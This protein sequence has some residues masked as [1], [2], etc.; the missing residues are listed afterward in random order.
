ML[1]KGRDAHRISLPSICETCSATQDVRVGK[2]SCRPQK[3]L[4]HVRAMAKSS[5]A[6]QSTTHLHAAYT[7]SLS[8]VSLSWQ[9]NSDISVRPFRPRV[10]AP[11]KPVPAASQHHVQAY[12]ML[13]DV[14][15]D[16]RQQSVVFTAVFSLLVLFLHYNFWATGTT[17][18][19]RPGL[20]RYS[21]R[22]AVQHNDTEKVP[23]VDSTD[24][25]VN[26]TY[27]ATLGV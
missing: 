1:T 7:T 10:P 26:A 22:I 24:D 4:E 3:N 9:L 12:T 6:S 5:L 17:D 23:V 21:Y 13:A 19:L 11:D 27:N 2:R 16:R 20:Q 25:F 14:L 15:A 18:T 8:F